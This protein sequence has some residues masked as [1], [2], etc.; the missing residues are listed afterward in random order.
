MKYCPNC[1]EKDIY[2]DYDPFKSGK[3]EKV[4][5]CYDCWWLGD[6]TQLMNKTQKTKFDR[7][8]KLMKIYENKKWICK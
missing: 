1:G 6:K 5:G 7:K 3:K 4:V 8:H 2:I